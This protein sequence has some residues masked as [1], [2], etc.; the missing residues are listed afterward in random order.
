VRAAEQ[1]IRKRG[2]RFDLAFAC[3]RVARLSGEPSPWLSEAYELARSIGAAKLVSTTKRTMEGCGVAVPV[4]RARSAEGSTVSDVE[5]RIVKLIQSGKTNRQIALALLMSEKT[6][7]KHL[8][9]LFAKAG[10]R[11]RHG[12][13]MYGLGGRQELVGA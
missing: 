5:R 6:V 3:Q 7:E 1:V 9:R 2:N 11:T 4:R 8:T 10:C 12:L 13:A